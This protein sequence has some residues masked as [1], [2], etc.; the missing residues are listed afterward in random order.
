MYLFSFALSNFV[1]FSKQVSSVSNG[2]ECPQSYIYNATQNKQIKLLHKRNHTMIIFIQHERLQFLPVCKH[3]IV[4][5]PVK[6][7]CQTATADDCLQLCSKKYQ[8]NCKA[9]PLLAFKN[10][11]FQKKYYRSQIYA[12]QLH[13]CFF[14]TSQLFW[15]TNNFRVINFPENSCDKAITFL[16]LLT[17]ILAF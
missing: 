12:E 8:I 2:F 14:L 10:L 4:N 5:F 9:R 16:Q 6:D 15:H 7:G 11:V 3:R 1:T 13:L 17:L